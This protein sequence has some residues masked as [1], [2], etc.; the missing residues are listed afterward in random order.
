MCVF[1]GTSPSAEAC[2]SVLPHAGSCVPVSPGAGTGCTRNP[3]LPEL[4][5][6]PLPDSSSHECLSYFTA[7]LLPECKHKGP[8]DVTPCAPQEGPSLSQVHREGTA[9]RKISQGEREW[10]E[11]PSCPGTLG[12]GVLASK[13]LT[14]PTCSVQRARER[15]GEW[16]GL[17]RKLSLQDRSHQRTEQQE[18]HSEPSRDHVPKSDVARA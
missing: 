4:Q 8:Q 14:A 15:G 2:L 18:A 16:K 12:T 11:R 13:G 3:S 6:T 10:P 9:N 1:W 17:P 7:T 5:P